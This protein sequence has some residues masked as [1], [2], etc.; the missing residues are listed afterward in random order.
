MTNISETALES[1]LRTVLCESLAEDGD[2]LTEADAPAMISKKTDRRIRSAIH[3]S[4]RRDRM[5]PALLP[6]KRAGV[7]L[8]SALAALFVLSMTVQPIRAAFW[9]AVVNWYD[10]VVR[11]VFTTESPFPATIEAVR[12]P[13]PVPEGWVLEGESV[14]ASAASYD[15]TDGDGR[16]VFVLQSVA[17]ASSETWFTRGDDVTVEQLP[18]RGDTHALLVAR[19]D[20]TLSLTWTEDYYFIL[21]GFGVDAAFLVAVA[22]GL[23]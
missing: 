19:E 9:N 23:K 21:T 22:E 7:A 4:A 18:I 17:N 16:F 8:A 6:W 1:A 10:S 3:K 2:W 5:T 12:R 15:L 13:E 11:V 14:S 20:G